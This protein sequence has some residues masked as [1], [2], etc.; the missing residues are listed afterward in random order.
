MAKNF[1][2]FKSQCHMK[3]E[4]KIP[5]YANSLIKFNNEAGGVWDLLKIGCNPYLSFFHRP[6][7]P[8]KACS[9]PQKIEKAP[10]MWTNFLGKKKWIVFVLLLWK[11][12]KFS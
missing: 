1:K 2:V 3:E 4:E 8:H 6:K 9:H 10:C 5:E 7:E 11:A 12:G